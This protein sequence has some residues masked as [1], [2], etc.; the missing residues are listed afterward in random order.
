MNKIF[1][2]ALL[3]IATL[4]LKLSTSQRWSDDE[5]NK[6]IARRF[7]EKFLERLDT[8]L[9]GLIDENEY[10]FFVN[11]TVGEIQNPDERKRTADVLWKDFGRWSKNGV[12][13]KDNLVRGITEKADD[14]ARFAKLIAD[15]AAAAA[16]QPPPP[17]GFAQIQ[18]WSDDHK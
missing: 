11:E 13:N 4:G 9:S 15:A 1:A 17:S 10:Q 14:D 6:E 12:A 3:S 16:A 2:A 18:G 8:D 5:H 7:A